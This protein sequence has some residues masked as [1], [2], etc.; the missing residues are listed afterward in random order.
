MME[1]CENPLSAGSLISGVRGGGQGSSN[2]WLAS[3][4]R[5]LANIFGSSDFVGLSVQPPELRA[6]EQDRVIK[7][8][9]EPGY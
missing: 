7:W 1:I 8:A 5:G 3:E 2:P 6:I 4:P 9:L